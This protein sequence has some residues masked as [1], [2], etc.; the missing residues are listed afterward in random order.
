MGTYEW[1]EISAV[2][3]HPDFLGRSYARRLLA[4]LGNDILARGMTPYLH[5]AQ[6]NARAV[7]V[8]LRGG[9]TLRR[10]IPFWSLQRTG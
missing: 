7:D 2:C 8:Y 4:M 6:E 3:T 9:F 5:V 1:R 10:E